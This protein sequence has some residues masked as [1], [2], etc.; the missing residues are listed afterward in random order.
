MRAFLVLSSALLFSLTVACGKSKSSEITWLLKDA[1]GDGLVD[2]YDNCPNA[3]N[4]D[5]RDSDLDRMGDACDDFTDVDLDTIND[6]DDNC[7]RLANTDQADADG[8]GRGDRCD[9]CPDVANPEQLD[10]DAN[11]VGDACICD[12]CDAEDELCAVH[13]LERDACIPAADCSTEQTCGDTCCGFGSRCNAAG[14]ACDLGDLAL[15][16]VSVSNSF[17][18]EELNFA[19]GTCEEAT[20]CVLGTGDRRL[21]RFDAI[22]DNIGEGDIFLGDPFVLIDD[23][24]QGTCSTAGV[25]YVP[26]MSFSL[27][28]GNV[29]VSQGET[30]GS[31][32]SDM[33][34]TDPNAAATATYDCDALTGISAGW[35]HRNAGSSPCQWVDITDVAPGPYTLR[36]ELNTEDTL[37]EA[38]Y[39]N[40]VIE[41]PFTVPAP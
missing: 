35:T 26:A 20:Q 21:L 16:P 11:G 14:T 34:R 25:Q 19:A 1:D 4:P 3:A 27:R 9:N 30:F 23:F 38:N 2:D 13:P 7:P 39:D 15:D 37:A 31:C 10:F 32:L 33:V 29:I 28:N 40:N 41:V 17:E 22:L 6:A 18:I 12:G 24:V 8:D 5:Q 36:I